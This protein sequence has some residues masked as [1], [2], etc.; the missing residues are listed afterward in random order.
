MRIS[1]NSIFDGSSARLVDLQSKMNKISEQVA[2]G[3]KMQT[4]SDDPVAAAQA[5]EV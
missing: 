2:S 3:R 4:P 5:L 1:T